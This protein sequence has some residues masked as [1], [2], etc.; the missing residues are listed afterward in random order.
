MNIKKND[1]S[2]EDIDSM[3][4]N[5]VLSSENPND[6]TYIDSNNGIQ[7][8]DTFINNNC[9]TSPFAMNG[10][11]VI[12]D[13]N[14]GHIYDKSV[15]STKP[16]GTNMDNLNTDDN[17]NINT[18]KDKVRLNINYEVIKKRKITPESE[19]SNNTCGNVKN[20]S[21]QST[22]DANKNGDPVKDGDLNIQDVS[23]VGF[24][25]SDTQFDVSKEEMPNPSKSP[26]NS[27]I[28]SPTNSPTNSPINSP[29]NS[30]I[31]SPINSPTNSNNEID[32]EKV[33]YLQIKLEQLLSETK[34]YTEKLCGQRLKIDPQHKSNKTR[35]C[36]LTEK[37]EDVMLLKEANEEDD[38]FII[39]QPS[40]VNGTM[41]GYQI[42]GL[43]WLYQLYRHNINGILADEM[44]LGK[45]LQTISL[46][47]YLRFNMNIKRKSIIICPRSTLDNW[48]E[49]IHKWCPEMK[50]FK[51]Y[52]NK[53]QRKELNKTV[54][55]NDYDVLLTTYEIVIKDKCALYDVEWFY[56][57]IDEAHRIKNDKSVLSSSVR[58]LKSEN[59]LLITG[60]PLH[61]NLKELWSLLNFL[62]PK[63]FD[64]S[65]EF[66][67]LFNIS[68]ISTNDNKQSE[69]I[70]QLHTIL[71]PFMLRRLKVEVEQ[72]LPPK[73]EIY[74]FVGMSRL[75][76]KLY[77]DILSK[78]IDVLNAMTGSKNQMLNILMQ[79]R[80]CCNHPYLFDGIEE[81]PYVEGPHLI[82]TSGKM[83]LL[84]KLLPRLKKENS[85]VLLFS[86]MT[87]LL[88]IIDDYCRW[89]QYE[90]LRIDGSTVGDERQIRINQFNEPN[91]KYFIFLLST[92]A[93][94]I[95][96]NLTTADIVILFDSDYNPQMDIQAMDRAHRIGQKKRVIVYRFVTQNTVEEKIVERAAKKLKLDSLIIQ[97]GKL[98]LNNKENNKQELHNILNFGAPEVYK[99]QDLCSISDK[100]I[101]IILA[102]AE[103]RT[104]EIENKLKNLENIFDLSNI[105]LDGGLNMYNNLKKNGS[106]GSSSED[107]YFSDSVGSDSDGGSPVINGGGSTG[108]NDSSAANG[109]NVDNVNS[110]IN[111]SNMNGVT[112][113]NNSRSGGCYLEGIS[114]KKNKNI[115][116]IRSTMK[117]MLKNKNKKNMI[118]L[119]LGE[120]KSK[121][122]VTNN[123]INNINNN[124][125]SRNKTNKKRIVL[126]GW[127]AEARGGYD[128]QFFDNERL[129]E[130]EKIEEKWNAYN[131]IEKKIK[132]VI[133]R[134][135]EEEPDFKKIVTVADFLDSHGKGIYEIMKLIEPKVF[136]RCEGS[137]ERVAS[138]KAT[139]EKVATETVP[140][141]VSAGASVEYK[142]DIKEKENMKS[143]ANGTI[144]NKDK[145]EVKNDKAAV[146]VGITNGSAHLVG[147]G[148]GS[149]NVNCSAVSMVGET[150]DD[151]VNYYK[152]KVLKVFEENK[153]A[154]NMFKFKNKNVKNCYEQFVTFL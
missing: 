10:E 30:P 142:V 85:R 84:D 53:E 77:S 102:D 96:I 117:K 116:K 151:N 4:H 105:S 36:A 109:N 32:G 94:G 132:E 44:G 61:N 88:D 49:E 144:D 86:Q 75:Q 81:P 62:M 47:C 15:S 101:D 35:R 99:T 118:F 125:N 48:Y 73:R 16:D 93:G 98:N 38:S 78:N 79:L 70:T 122:K 110:S 39:K 66:D 136:D 37:E 9:N 25:S 43:N 17:M 76:K 134:Y 113:N 24:E 56:L 112:S 42:E 64:N 111:G 89:K 126:R 45:T 119:D 123:S 60:T 143:K 7:K 31:N 59:R 108:V 135:S 26:T 52:G 146:R 2:S 138:E 90:Y 92:R 137:I 129:D 145:L 63:T 34:K 12:E 139:G 22:Y 50:A 46:L 54:L 141:V 33:N 21:E 127:K 95:G 128:F 40:N 87:R 18:R 51:Y 106:D 69:I 130:L 41:K 120:R 91:S 80:K 14:E 1:D 27:P 153:K 133:K 6:N 28:N 82:E 57:V 100:D 55:H 19:G 20:D 114:K 131:L 152:K 23:S 58:F 13:I 68:K 124:N 150:P 149:G 5:F 67:N 121:W 11:A 71:K 83:S 148:S 3:K 115:H 147:S 154:L 107:E 74:I 140:V 103:K 97:K 29:T 65:E 72:S 104:M 8:K